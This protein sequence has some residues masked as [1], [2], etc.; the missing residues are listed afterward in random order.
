MRG[1]KE[2]LFWQFA[3]VSLAV[4]GLLALLLSLSLGR[5]IQAMVL[6]NAVA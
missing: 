2:G 4:M 5:S 6:D 1:L 3:L